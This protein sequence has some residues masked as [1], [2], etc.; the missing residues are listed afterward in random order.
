M[1][2]AD[3][4]HSKMEKGIYCGIWNRSGV[5]IGVLDFSLSAE[6]EAT[7]A[8]LMIS[9]HYRNKGYGRA[10]VLNLE[11]YL[12]QK[13]GVTQIRSGVQVNNDGGIQFWKKMGYI[14]S[15]IARE[16]GDGTTTY[17]MTKGI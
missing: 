13:Y 4:A 14:I 6:K 1:V 17:E 10:I 12:N 3:I 9:Q 11:Y 2:L 7:L 8:L 5:Q 15:E 16:M